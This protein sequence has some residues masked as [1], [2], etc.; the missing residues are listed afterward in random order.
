MAIKCSMKYE[1]CFTGIKALFKQYSFPVVYRELTIG[2]VSRTY[3]A[4]VNEYCL[5]QCLETIL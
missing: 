2:L 3:S 1:P 5:K 4:Q